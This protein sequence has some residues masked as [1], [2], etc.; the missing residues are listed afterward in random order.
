[1]FFKFHIWLKILFVTL[2]S[3]SA[4]AQNPLSFSVIRDGDTIGTHTF[5]FSTEGDIKKVN[6]NTEM[7][8]KVAFVTVFNYKHNREEKWKGNQLVG[9][10][11]KTDYDGTPHHLNVSQEKESLVLQSS[12]ENRTVNAKDEL[13]VT[14]WNQ[15]ITTKQ[16]LF[17]ALNGE[18]YNVSFQKIGNENITV[19]GKA[20]QTTHYSMTGELARELW[21]DEN[22][23]LVKVSFEKDGTPIEYVRQ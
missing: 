3:G 19:N 13:P 10:V 23:N 2:I 11:S 15:N 5:T 1:M 22:N 14:L 20:Y 4:F 12:L 6:V 21:Y 9:M 7:K 17:S 16:K 8:V 18:P